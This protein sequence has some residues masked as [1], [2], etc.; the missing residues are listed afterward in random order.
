MFFFFIFL[1]YGNLGISYDNVGI[2]DSFFWDC[3]FREFVR[4]VNVFCCVCDDCFY[5]VWDIEVFGW[6]NSNVNIS[7]D[8]FCGEVE[9]YVVR[10]IDL[11]NFE[12]VEVEI[13]VGVWGEGFVNGKEVGDGLERMV[14][15]WESVDDRDGGVFG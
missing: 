14:G 6:G 9:E 2:F 5:V 13:R 3:S 10:V 7:F 4:W 11:G 8:I 12:V 1:I 15:V